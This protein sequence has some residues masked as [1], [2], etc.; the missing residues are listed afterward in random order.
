MQVTICTANCTGQAANCSYPNK[1]TV[2]TPRQLQEAVKRDHVCGEFQGNYR[3]IWNFLRSNVIVMD[4][5][6]DH[7]ED[8]AEWVTPEKL[9]ELF[10]NVEYLLAPSRHHLLAKE[11]KSPRPRY[12]VYFPIM[13]I[14]DAEQYAKLKKTIWQT[15]PFFD[16]NA[17]D[18]ARFIFGAECEEVI[19][20]EGWMTIDEE[21]GGV[22]IKED[23]DADRQENVASGPILV[24]SR[25]NTMSRFAGRVLKKYGVTDKA[26]EA[27]DIHARRCDPPLPEEELNTIWNSAVRFYKK[28][29]V[30]QEGYVAP[31]EYNAEFGTIKP[32]DYSDM[33]EARALVDEYKDE[34]LYTDATEFLSYDGICWRENRQKAVGAVEEFL[35]MQLV[36]AKGQFNDCSQVLINAGIPEMTVRA[37][38]KALEKLITPELMDPYKE[39]LAA[40]A[41]YAFVMKYRNFKNIVNT[42]NAAKPMVAADI[43]MFDAQEN[44]LNTP[45]ATYDLKLG[46][47]G[48][49]PHRATDLLTKITNCA[50]GD[51]GKDLWEEAL[52]LFFCNDQELI[53]YVQETVGLAA[54]GKVYVEAL[55]IS[56]GEGRNGKSTFWNTISR[57]MGTYSGAMSAD[58]LTAGCRRNVKPEIAE[59]KGKRLVIAAELEEGMRLSTSILKQLCST[60]QIRGEKKFKDPFDFT[61]SHTVVLYTNHLPKV[62]ASDDGTWRRLIV[63][64]FHAKIE[65]SSDIKNYS[66]YLYEHAGPA[67][68]SWIIEGAQKVIAHEYK[69]KPP[70]VVADAI[71]EYRGMN[72]WLSQFLEDCCEVQDGLEE[73]S[74]E[75]YQEYRAYCLRTGEY[76]RNNADFT[77]ALEK[78]GFLRKKKKSGM[79]V[80]GV[81]LKSEDFA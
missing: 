52:N 6:N 49:R 36:D 8:A 59:L 11:G 29:I 3:S 37:G 33:G 15:Y 35:D 75:L 72:D 60:D 42:Q 27:F 39:Y 51:E 55:I 23:A 10:A 73:K 5:D 34:L 18:A 38:G 66:D 62:G 26:K 1:V 31:D 13:E 68:M 57:V 20:H 25:N 45:S 67:V 30:T 53:D 80:Q 24:G 47:A 16:G 40:K 41:Y 74:G 17:L 43:N 14:T 61:P 4:I 9:E 12:H 32:D 64:P 46:M 71:A 63:L 81:Q 58:A 69:I 50:P 19:F 44:F 77:A 2:T 79:W 48:E 76:A 65:G 70:K 21:V 22:E 56:Y 7:T 78:R 28:T 54:I